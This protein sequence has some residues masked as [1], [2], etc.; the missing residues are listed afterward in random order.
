MSK[1]R[2]TA[3][4]LLND[5]Q[6]EKLAARPPELDARALVAL[7]TKQIMDIMD[8]KYL[9]L[10]EEI[11]RLRWALQVHERRLHGRWHLLH[12]FRLWLQTR[13]PEDCE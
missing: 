5:V 2:K 13:S 7:H 3:S 1:R 4:E 8:D 11:R 12:R 6:R 9:A 10:S